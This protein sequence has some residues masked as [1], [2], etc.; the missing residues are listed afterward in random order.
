MEEW[1]AGVDTGLLLWEGCPAEFFND[2]RLGDTLDRLFRKGTDSVFGAVVERFLSTRPAQEE[3]LVPPDTTTLSL[4]GAYVDDYR[5]RE[6]AE[7]APRPTRGHS[8]DLRPDL[9]Q[10]VYCMSLHGPTGV[11]LA[12]SMLNGNTSDHHANRLQ[13]DKLAELLPPAHEVTLVADCKFVDTTTLG[14]DRRSGFNYVSL[15]P[16]TFALRTELVEE[17]RLAGLPL[18]EVGRYSGRTLADPEKVCAAQS[19]ERAIDVTNDETGE[20][21]AIPHGLVVVRSSSG[22]ARFD[23]ALPNTLATE[24]K[25]LLR[26]AKEVGK[27]DFPCEADAR[28][29]RDLLAQE[30]PLHIVDVRVVHNHER[31]KRKGPGRPR[32]DERVDVYETWRVVVAGLAV[33]EAAVSRPRF[34]ASH[35]VLV[36]SRVGND[37]WTAKRVFEA[38]RA[39]QT[40]EGHTGFRWVKDAAAIAPVFLKLPHRIAALGMVFLLALMVRN[41][42]EGTLRAELARRDEALPDMNDRMTPRPSAEARCVCTRSSRGSTSSSTTS[43]ARGPSTAYTGGT[44]EM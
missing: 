15:L 12:A 23:A 40:I 22:Q 30:A 9:L 37:A 10:L 31:A 26:A 2:D 5:N 27:Q 33:D 16:R 14:W 34:H 35:F 18:D 44:N 7:R 41:W 21:E 29:A 3:Y 42:I 25:A 38:Y 4:Q 6:I 19:C 28:A 17:V 24:Q 11:P 39:Q 8:K 36:S 20:V 32:N 13:I 43:F 1:L